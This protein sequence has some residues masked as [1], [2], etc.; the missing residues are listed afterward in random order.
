MDLS[1]VIVSWNVERLLRENLDSI[2]KNT[3]KIN[4]EIFVV[5]NNSDDNTVKMIESEF[6]EVKLIKNNINTGFSKA[7]NQ[8][9]K[10]SIGRY[11]LLLNPDMRIV[12]GTL[13][14]IVDWMDKNKKVGISSCYLVGHDGKTVKHVRRFPSVFDQ[15]M[16]VLKIPHILP[17]VLNNYLM[18]DFNYSH[19]SSVDSVR[20]SFFM[21]RREMIKD[22]GLLDESYFIWFEEVDYC[23]RAKN[24]NWGVSYV[25]GIKCVDYVG[26]S[27]EIVSRGKKQIYFRNSMLYYFEKWHP[28]WQYILLRIAW[29]VGMVLSKMKK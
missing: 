22:V 8:A 17:F 9:I 16:V 24:N 6:P 1:I 28:R 26:K 7:N 2:Y 4:F 27:F 14:D 13:D 12:E 21:M 3:K 10:E 19:E 5:D 23:K 18:S 29:P 25:P 15:L 20:G 11:V